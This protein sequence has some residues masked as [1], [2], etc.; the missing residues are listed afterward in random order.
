MIL[1]ATLNTPGSFASMLCED[2][3]WMTEHTSKVEGL[4]HPN[5]NL[6]PWLS[7]SISN[8]WMNAVNQAFH[9]SMCCTQD[10]YRLYNMHRT[11]ARMYTPKYAPPAFVAQTREPQSNTQYVCYECGYIAPSEDCWHNHPQFTHKLVPD[12]KC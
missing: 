12:S 6:A 11:I 3:F 4:E 7:F 10:K 5:L 8:G 2:I 1:D 9:D